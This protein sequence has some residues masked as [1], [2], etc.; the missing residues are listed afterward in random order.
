MKLLKSIIFL[1]AV[2]FQHL[3]LS[4]NCD[5]LQLSN[6]QRKFE[7]G[8][9]EEVFELLKPCVKSST[10]SQ[11]RLV[12]LR[13]LALSNFALDSV[14]DAYENV[15]ELLEIN[16]NYQAGLFD[17]PQFAKAIKEL[18]KQ[19]TS[20]FVTSVSKKAEDVKLT[21]GTVI[22]IDAQEIRERGYT[23]LEALM[24]DLP[25]FD[26]SRTRAATYSN[27]Y[28]RG[29]RGNNTDRTLFMVDGVEENDLWSN[30]M[31]FGTQFP[32]SNIKQVEIIY[33]PAS[34]MYGPNA[35]SGVINIITK[36]PS[37]SRSGKP[38]SAYA[39]VGYGT[40]NTRY[41][42]AYAAGRVSNAAL[43]LTMRRYESNYRDLSEFDEYDFNPA[44]YDEIDYQSLLTVSPAA[45]PAFDSTYSSYAN[46]SDFYQVT[47]NAEGQQIAVPTELAQEYARNA[48]KD[49]VNRTING[50]PIGYA[51]LADNIFLEAKL[52]L[53][54]FTFGGQYWKSRQGAMDYRTD[55]YLAGAKNATIWVPVQYHIYGKYEREII[56]DKL[57][58]VDFLQYRVTSV[59]DETS[60]SVLRNYSNRS[61]GPAALMDSVS[62]S[63]ITAYYYQI[64]RQFRN[65]L[66]LN[67]TPSSKFD[68]VSGL[69]LRNSFIQGDYYLAIYSEDQATGVQDF[70]SVIE[71]G[72]QSV[73]PGGGNYYEI[74]EVGAF[75]QGT[76]KA[77]KWLNIILGGRYDY[78]RIRVS[79]GYGSVFN[80]R[81]AVVAYPGNYIFKVI[82]A[83]AFQNASNWTKFAT[84][85]NRQL[86]NPTL[87]P[88]EVQNV[89]V[90]LG[91]KFSEHLFADVTYYNA[92]Y[93]GSV[94]PVP[95][96]FNGGTTLQNQAVGELKIQGIQ[97]NVSW[98]KNNYKAYFNYTFTSPFNN[99]IENGELTE[100]FE[101][102]G[103]IASHQFNIG[104]NAF[105]FDHLNVNLRFNYVGERETGPGTSVPA[106]MRTFDPVY[107]LNGALMYKNLL[108]HFD[109]QFGCNNIFDFQYSDPGIRTADGVSNAMA[110][111]QLGRNY[112]VKLIYSLL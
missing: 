37:T 51:N 75:A 8:N 94:A 98:K 85:D 15:V 45:F 60:V 32:L 48:D 23:D 41:I 2:L 34:T 21:P 49:G 63:W 53:P 33:G 20:I 68:L 55:N 86:T 80:P 12:A 54:H 78:N 70:P 62:A 47:T 101:R 84:F 10:N 65:E 16:P 76:Y 89:D 112:Y 42:D 103:D 111:P 66:K 6:A 46:Y 57:S 26:I 28:Q 36:D 82:Y 24:S 69:E 87:P 52:Q 92:T 72:G 5:D 35:F 105:Y 64:S 88:E 11:Q 83:S 43:S 38:Y 29:Y 74:M 96:P 22:V 77:N 40:Y 18:K 1:T 25:G 110:T 106:N 107:L 4:Q 108:P 81:A 61:L 95:V 67:Y 99:R 97:S 91:Y 79:G 27:I 30:I 58:I 14:G 3:A 19:N 90:S 104:L 100:D 13:L 31:Y 44:D 71:T 59:D 93:R 56:K 50:E 17:P 39:E 73:V 109:L 102:I 9:F 7:T